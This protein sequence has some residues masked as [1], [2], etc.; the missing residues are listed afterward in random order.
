LIKRISSFKFVCVWE[1]SYI[2]CMDVPSLFDDFAPA[3]SKEYKPTEADMIQNKILEIEKAF[4]SGKKITAIKGGAGTG[5]TTLIKHIL[6]SLSSEYRICYLAPTNK[7]LLQINIEELYKIKEEQSYRFAKPESVKIGTVQS[8]CGLR[9]E[10]NLIGELSF[11]STYSGFI[12]YIDYDLVIID[13]ASM[14]S[15]SHFEHICKKQNKIIIVGDPMQLPPVKEE[16]FDIF[17]YAEYTLELTEKK[18]Y[19][20][21]QIEILCEKLE[22]AIAENKDFHDFCITEFIQRNSSVEI[23]TKKQMKELCKDK[24]YIS[25]TNAGGFFYWLE[26]NKNHYIEGKHYYVKGISSALNSR[27]KYT[28]VST[29]NKERTFKNPFGDKKDI[30]I[31]YKENVFE[32]TSEEK[33][34]QETVLCYS[35]KQKEAMQYLKKRIL[36]QT[37]KAGELE[38]TLDEWERWEKS[39]QEKAFDELVSF[40]KK[41][42]FLYPEDILT[43]HYSQGSTIG[44]VVVD[45]G[46]YR[47]AKSDT[48]TKEELNLFKLKLLY[49]AVSRASE[50]LYIYLN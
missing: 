10:E 27:L 17:S 6:L 45:I 21:K 19:K 29:Q 49:V 8:A 42:C 25:Y 41:I 20:N 32:F 7:A 26:N 33:Q 44:N 37:K 48:L 39:E 23:I 47:Y 9:V 28:L 14:V 11:Y 3:V 43:V 30:K 18:R 46:S 5:K 35:F 50:N 31:E 2:C 24:T 1:R 15:K 16:T 22:N 38:L 40:V 4:Y 13:E 12:N 34:M 36:A